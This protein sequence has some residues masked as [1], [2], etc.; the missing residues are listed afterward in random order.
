MKL[1]SL[2]V[3]GALINTTSAWWGTGHM[4]VASIAEKLMQQNDPSSYKKA[5]AMLQTLTKS[6]PDLVKDEGEH[7]FVECSIL[8]D[9]IKSHG[10][11]F[12]SGWHFVDQPFLDEGGDINDFNFTFDSHNVTEAMSALRDWITLAD[13]YKSTYEYTMLMQ[14]IDAL[15][16]VSGLSEDDGASL[17]LRL[18]IHYAGDIHQPLHAESRV[19][20]KYPKGDRGGNSFY[21]PRNDSVSNLHAAFDS[22]FFEFTGFPV[23]PFTSSKWESLSTSADNLMEKYPA[24]SLEDLEDTDFENWAAGSFKITEEFVYKEIDHQE[25][26]ALPADYIAKGQMYTERQ[27][28]IAGY[29]LA[30]TLSVMFK[31]REAKNDFL[32]LEK[33]ELMTMSTSELF[34]N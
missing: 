16:K 11:S 13:D 33:S 29:R 14:N 27:I 6:A 10:G 26:K 18:F 4:L 17:A 5:T 23:M 21:L 12:Q 2:T 34:L 7:S 19:D 8:A 32:A 1:L 15:A 30:N 31:A 24:S 3:V 9:G 20:S 25:G 22:V 28:V